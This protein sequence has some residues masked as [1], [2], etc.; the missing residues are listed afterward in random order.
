MVRTIRNAFVL[1]AG[2]GTR[3]R[4]LTARRPKPLIPVCQKPLITFAFDHLIR[5]GIRRLTINTH[6][7]PEVYGTV[8][9]EGSYRGVPLVFRHEP[10]LLETA[11]GIG[12]VADLLGDEP[13]V[14]YNGDILADLPVERLIEGHLESG[15]EVTLAL[16]SHGGP[17]HVSFDTDS[18]H[19]V[20]I[21]RRLGTGAAQEYLFSG[22]YAVSP[23]FL[24][25]IPAGEKISVVP[26][27]LEMISSGANLGGVVIDDGRW[28]DL[29]TREEYLNA[30]RS[31]RSDAGDF[32]PAGESPVWV[33]PTAKV[34]ATA[35]VSGATAIGAG[36]VVGEGARL[37]DCV[38]WERARVEAQSVLDNCIVTTDRT[39][40]GH[41]NGGDF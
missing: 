13:F 9:P 32:W 38:L 28:F 20:D 17:L 24:R 23:E 22:V 5:S 41:H 36:A 27:F 15:N 37:R 39:A 12:N 6:H 29:G 11:G 34:A 10:I 25:R 35:E 40:S 30:H 1:G 33:H 7:C 16:R 3:L 2:L 31:L 8:F 14:V 21:R 18:G 26:I 4:E 19:V